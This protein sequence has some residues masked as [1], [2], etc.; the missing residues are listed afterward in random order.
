MRFGRSL[1]SSG[2]LRPLAYGASGAAIL[3]TAGFVIKEVGHAKN[4]PLQRQNVDL[5]GDGVPESV[6]LFDPRTGGGQ[7][8]GAQ[9]SFQGDDDRSDERTRNLLIV[10]GLLAVVAVVV[11]RGA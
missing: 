6:Y 9:P 4:P 7:G 2:A 8:Y 11:L 5:N 10:G 3:G 1:R